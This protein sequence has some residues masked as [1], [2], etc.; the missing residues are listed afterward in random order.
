MVPHSF[1]CVREALMAT[2]ENKIISSNPREMSGAWTSTLYDFQRY[3]SIFK[4]VELQESGVDYRIAFDY[5]DDIMIFNHSEK[6][7]KIELY[8]V[9][10]R[11]TGPWQMT[12]LTG[13]DSQKRPSSIIGKMYHNLV[14]FGPYITKITFI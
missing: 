10:S 4:I 14:I 2:I 6:P 1:S 12:D 3:V 8:Q 7:T 5:F 11:L 9:K 13:S